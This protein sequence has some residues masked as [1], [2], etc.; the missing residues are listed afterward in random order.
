METGS[1]Y[2][3]M[4]AQAARSVKGNEAVVRA[5]MLEAVSIAERIAP[6]RHHRLAAIKVDAKDLKPR[7]GQKSLEQLRVQMQKH[8][9]RLAPVLDLEALLAPSDG[10]AN[11]EVQEE[12]PS[13]TG[14][15]LSA[16]VSPSVS[17]SPSGNGGARRFRLCSHPRTD[18]RPQVPVIGYP[19]D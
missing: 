15:T 6:Y 5:N 11:R 3:F 1:R 8:W 4:R 2:F 9:E 17:A 13:G 7:D 14:S 10:I 18:R 12:R 16:P 19:V